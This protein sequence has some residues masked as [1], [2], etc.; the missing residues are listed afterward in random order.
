MSKTIDERVVEMRF[1]N[2]QF[3]KNV[4]TTMSTLDK[5]KQKLNLTGASKGL[6]NVSAAASKFDLSGIGR[7]AETVG[8]KFNAMYTIADQ[9]LRN[10]TN[11]AVIAGQRI[12]TALTID[13]ITTGF[14]EYELKM[15]SVQTI[16]ASTGESLASVNQYL[17]ELNEYSDKTIY[18]FSDMTQNIGK[19]TNAGIKLEDAVMAI[20]GI[21]N[22]AAVSGANAN[23]ASR[24]MYNFAQALSAGYVK[25]IDWKSIENAN[26]ATVEFK[27]EL[28][29]TAVEMKTLTKVTDGY[30]TSSGKVITATKNF[31]DSLQDEWMTSEVLIETLKKY[32]DETT[33]IGK[34]SSAAA[35]EVKTFTQLFDTLAESAQSGWA[36]TWE[37][38]VGDF[39]EAKELMT[40]LSKS[41]GGIIDS[42]SDWRNNLIEGAVTSKWEKLASKIE[43]A[44]LSTET[45]LEKIK[46][47]YEENG[48]S[49]DELVEKHGSLKKAIQAGKIP[50]NILTKALGKLLGAENELTGATDE[51]THSMEEYKAIANR[52][53]N[54]EFGVGEGRIKALA[55]AGYDYATVQNLVN[56]ALG[57][58]VRHTSELTES[59]LA[60]AESLSKLSDEQLKEKGY[61]EEQI[62]ALRELKAAA[63]ESGGS[64][65]DLIK[66]MEK[67]SGR[68]LIIQSFKN[69][70]TA[71]GKV[72]E[73][74]REAWNDV[75]DQKL[76]GDDIYGVIVK[77]EEL[78]RSM[79]IS[80]EAAANFK[81]VMEGLFTGFK[82]GGSLASKTLIGGIKLLNA[83][84]SLFGTDILEVAAAIA[85]YIIVF[86]EWVETHTIFG[87]DTAIEDIA[88]II[89]AL[90]E[91]IKKCI[92][93][94]LGLDE[95][96]KIIESFTDALVTF[97]N[98]FAGFLD[99]FSV[100]AI[101][102]NIDKFFT[103]IETW[104]KNG[105][106][107]EDLGHYIIE[108]LQN[109]LTDGLKTAVSIFLDIA[110]TL[111]TEFCN[112]FGIESPSKLMITLGGFIIAGLV[113]GLT[114][115]LPTV[116]QSIQDL[117]TGIVDIL[118]NLN[119]GAIIAGVMSVGIIILGKRILDILE[120]FG[121]LSEGLG[122]MFSGIGSMFKNVGKVFNS[123][124]N[125]IDAKVWETRSTTI[126]NFAK[127]IG[128]LAVSV[129][130]LT[131][132]DQDKLWNAVWA[133]GALAGIV[134]G[135][136]LVSS[137]MKNLK[138]S[139]AVTA[140]G[141][142]GIS[143][144]LLVLAIALKVISSI[145][146]GDTKNTLTIFAALIGGL[147][148]LMIVLG[149]FIKG[150]TA[151]NLGKAGSMFMKLAAAL[152]ILALVVKVISSFDPHDIV[153]GVAFIASV[154]LLYGAI[155]A[156][157]K[158]SGKNANKA[159][160]MLAKMAFA[161]LMMVGV[162]KLVSTC[163]NSEIVR[164]LAF[165][166]GV[167]ALFAGLLLIS[168]ISGK[169]VNK[170]G[171]LLMGMAS[172]ILI[173]VIAIKLIAGI[174]TDDIK[175]GL[176]TIA[177]IEVMFA[178]LVAVS[179]FAG[180]HAARAGV[181]LLLMSGAM[182]VLT[183]IMYILG[184]IK[185]E[186]AKKAL[187]IIT[188]LELLFG[189]LIAISHFSKD[190]ANTVLKMGIA[191]AILAAVVVALSLINPER[192]KP[193]VAAVGLLMVAFGTLI[194]VTNLAKNT[195]QM[196]RTLFT[197]ASIVALLAVIV[198]ALSH[199]TDPEA[200]LPTALGLSA[201][202]VAFG[203]A[204]ALI[205]QAGRV[206]KTA[207]DAMV[208]ML[209]VTLGLA[210]ILGALSA[211][212]STYGVSALIPSTIALS[213]LLEAFSA[214]IVIL[215]M[216]G[217]VSKTAVGTLGAMVEVTAALATIL[218]VMAVMMNVGGGV[219][220]LIPSTIALSILLEAFAASIVIL[221]AA[222]SISKSVVGV[223]DQMTLITAKLA[224]ILAALSAA[225]SV[226][227]VEAMIPSVI[228]LS[229]LLE[230]FSAS[231]VIL[232]MAG[233]V[234]KSVVGVLNN[235][236]AIT[237]GLATI[238]YLLSS[239]TT[240]GGGVSALI[241]S[242]IALSILLEAFAASI[243]IL[244]MAGN[245]SASALSALGPMTAVTA[246]LALI[247]GVM[248]KLD[249]T[250]SLETSLALSTLLIGL[251]VALG[252]LSAIGPVA[253]MA[254][255]AIVGLGK[256]V[257]GLALILAALGALSMI[258][259]A[260]EL[261]AGGGEM[262]FVIGEAIGRFVGAIVG[263][264]A[265]GAMDV[266]TKSLPAMGEALSNFTTN[267][268][269]F[270]KSLVDMANPDLVTGANALVQLIL[271]ITAANVISGIQSLFG[272]GDTSF[273][274]FGEQL[275]G[276][277]TSLVAFANEL[278]GFD[279]SKVATVTC[280]ANA[281]K[282]LAEASKSLP[283]EG[284]WAAK[285]LGEN[286]IATF[287]SYLPALGTNMAAFITNLG[288]FD[289][290]Q[291]T[292]VK[293]AGDAIAALAK[294]AQDIPNDGG[295]LG[296]I[297]GENSIS[298]FSGELPGLGAN[299]R[300]FVNNLG[301][302][303][304]AT[305][306]T[307]TCAANAIAALAKGASQIDG[308]ADWAKKIFGD[309]S[310]SSFSEEIVAVGS[311]IKGFTDKLGT[312]TEEKV[313]TVK[314]AVNAIKALAALAD[315]DLKGAK[316]N[317]PGFGDNIVELAIDLKSFITDMPTTDA[318][319]NAKAGI[320]EIISVIDLL[321][322]KD[323]SVLV[324]FSANLKSIGEKGVDNFIHAFTNTTAVS[325]IKDAGV[326]VISNVIK[327]AESKE[328]DLVKATKSIAQEGADGAS[329]K[330]SAFKSAGKD[331]GDGLVEGIEAKEDDAYDAGYALGQAAVQGEKDGQK[332]KSPSKLTIQA[333]KWLGEGLVIGMEAMSNTVYKSGRGLGENAVDPISST[334]SKIGDILSND[335]DAQ[336]T[337]R[338]VLDLSEV[339]AG[340]GAINGMLDMNP[341]IGLMANVRSIGTLANNRQNGVNDDVISAIDRLGKTLGNLPSGNT[342]NVNGI[343]YDDG[344][345]IAGAIKD[346]ARA[347][348]RERRV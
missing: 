73:S 194:G 50:A 252:I 270:F 268:S 220:A 272:L 110:K 299:L 25:L 28:I 121:S 52:V 163:D 130:L 304:D 284:G 228:A 161:V 159:G 293:C 296:V 277:G 227:G 71:V 271:A 289:E 327:G 303:D 205:G 321:S 29:K 16:M 117:C 153:K 177:A 297:F 347:A 214:S 2:T 23:E 210:V 9:A 286:S 243:V 189:G 208:P 82:L 348:L 328:D 158:L 311:N 335:I 216:A 337:I 290:A 126:L 15:N 281:I 42:I 308:Q 106:K 233:T 18:S 66:D 309:N 298:T 219:E 204:I 300:S 20:K 149:T 51:M 92:K 343:T 207:Q 259:G 345:N 225:M 167:E 193:A 229:I 136:A 61:T 54:G 108:G 133:I 314:S 164:G 313:A 338:P 36:T 242:T 24:A 75:F 132:V 7:A 245:V 247:L 307:V 326:K 258:P 122:D 125:V 105:H 120:M 260:A 81:T 188:V 282:V 230:A 33:E 283:N 241:P 266:I 10:I 246:G 116:W 104:I 115:S 96:D 76:T 196:I 90:Y 44:G 8:L 1:D 171:G 295:W 173:T 162:V 49:I 323:S 253:A 332:S 56:E 150:K 70:G 169:E 174:S 264:I 333:G 14:N 31:N 21:S 138:L 201:L 180:Q 178:A 127:A 84:L 265:G 157:G 168:R 212:M 330:K 344:S 187:G 288:T 45:Y 186:K 147:S 218:G 346:I 13:P 151:Q 103:S 102:E 41:I 176:A 190:C 137:V 206:T 6:E 58:T 273:A 226:C 87:F 262:L 257:A 37:L 142:V 342:Y 160:G 143:S 119:I 237:A 285:I 301:T 146:A 294:A 79:V 88:R 63:D 269:G 339:S 77:I 141:M 305:V 172:A 254:D 276:L 234:S 43:K 123:L 80:E 235:M 221:G 248:A 17:A 222:G 99:N 329:D 240:A 89:V 223:L 69:I 129:A 341:S 198:G 139:F 255:I 209:A 97:F 249:I 67:A 202:V 27:E 224:I 318:L 310:L 325:D 179:H 292:T 57:S 40:S 184:E 35:T 182:A 336:P 322:S 181:M 231:I 144:A 128:I 26:M 166:A 312:F 152:L 287:G 48:E 93:A 244:S 39:E 112:F 134:A 98:K 238:L 183:V 85:E 107:F 291:V 60:N 46:E 64:I 5:F 316:N 148:A 195:K 100:D 109:G 302:F 275:A 334:I 140:A 3:E 47:V 86:G 124:S 65:S 113:L 114:G 211:A 91:G 315:A 200:V 165:V 250:A 156:L 278:E 131:Y 72:F 340:A 34:K 59:Q 83:V 261:L 331:L 101:V 317:L 263:G 32:A 185:P 319:K 203:G 19:F 191:I 236:L 197:M 217:T 251:S 62:Q 324:G 4:A 256:V 53:I 74:I 155:I 38:L 135:L 175:R 111:V 95:A 239:L 213:I 279:E 170:V 11:S 215:S 12:V 306:A 68:D 199:Y 22:E 267:A 55:E 232:S 192:L 30:E 118:K 154:G 78:T 280:A 94:F 320:K 145:D 274:S